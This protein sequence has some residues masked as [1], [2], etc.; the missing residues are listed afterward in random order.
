MFGPSLSVA[1]Q[2]RAHVHSNSISVT[3]VCTCAAAVAT[4]R[5]HA[6]ALAPATSAAHFVIARAPSWLVLS[7][8]CACAIT[9]Y[10]FVLA[11]MAVRLPEGVS[12]DFFDFLAAVDHPA[13]RPVDQLLKVIDAFRVRLL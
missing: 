6:C 7:S 10:N 2:R 11:S 8:I 12:K 3:P 5:S 9:H 1:L 4:R 13:Q